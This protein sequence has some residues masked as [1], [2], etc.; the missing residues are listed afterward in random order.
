[1]LYERVQ[2][3]TVQ[4]LEEG[5]A[6]GLAECRAQERA[7]QARVMCRMAARKFDE[8]VATELA[9]RLEWIVDPEQVTE[10]G[11]WLIE[12]E[13]G[14]ELLAR[15][16]E[17]SLE[18]ISEVLSEIGKQREAQ[19]RAEG[20]A[21]GLATG[22]AQGRANMA[23]VMCRMVARKFDQGTG[24][25]LAGPLAENSDPVWLGEIGEWLID[26]EDGDELLDRVEA[27]SQR[28]GLNETIAAALETFSEFEVQL[29]AEGQ[30][31]GRA[32][33]RAEIMLRQAVRKFGTAT[34]EHF[35]GLLTRIADSER[36]G[37]IGEW[38][39]DCEDGNELLDRMEELCGISVAGTEP[40]RG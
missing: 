18:H 25:R 17:P 6:E 32:R 38:L 15:V 22:R 35:A 11:E 23:E 31:Q 3:W 29:R 37:E 13:D 26:C 21:E 5:R 28:D 8:R 16:G 39:I 20:R 27:P 1:M 33:G 36:V 34:A 2:Q 12:C 9:E 24:E 19:W 14:D 30:A 10:I 7:R 4:W 40:P